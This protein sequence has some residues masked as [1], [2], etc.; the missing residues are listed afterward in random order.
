MKIIENRLYLDAKPV[1]WD[2]DYIE[3]KDGVLYCKD[4]VLNKEVT[5][6]SGVITC[7]DCFWYKHE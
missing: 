7:I 2:K 1:L 5:I 3:L 4:V 6:V